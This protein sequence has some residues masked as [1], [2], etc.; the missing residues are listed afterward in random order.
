MECRYSRSSD[1]TNLCYLC[2]SG[3]QL[4][5]HSFLLYKIAS[6]CRYEQE[7]PSIRYDHR[8]RY[9]ARRGLK[10][11]STSVMSFRVAIYNL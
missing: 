5:T 7:F 9:A 1:S 2:R 4:C 6:A 10:D 11:S 3:T 8:L